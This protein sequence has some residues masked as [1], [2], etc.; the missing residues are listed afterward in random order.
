MKPIESTLFHRVLPP[1]HPSDRPPPLLIMLHGRGADE[2][3]LPGLAG[4]LGGR[5]LVV[6][7]RAPLPFPYGGFTWYEHDEIGTP[8]T[9][10]F[11]GSYEKLLAFV[12]EVKRGY[13][14]DPARTFLFGFSMGSV[15]SFA[16]SL[17]HP[18]LFAGVVANSGYIPEGTPLQFRW[19]DLAHTAFFIGH[20]TA[21]PVIPIQL[22][23]RAR[24]LFAHSTVP[25]VYREY[26]VE[27]QI[28]DAGIADVAAWLRDHLDSRKP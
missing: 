14:V 8:E 10:T 15:M 25:F 5:F 13:P 27:H 19:N 12:E 17:T 26:P 11:I 6:S 18:E 16:L 3:D 9:N 23:R 7:P 22:A 28:S 2:E 20:G 4:L 21:D 24:D 1:E